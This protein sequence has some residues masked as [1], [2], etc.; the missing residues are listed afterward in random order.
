MKE[1]DYA[2]DINFFLNFVK[3]GS[4]MSIIQERIEPIMFNYQF[5]VLDNCKFRNALSL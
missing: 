4:K 2:K 3:D 5:R 1:I